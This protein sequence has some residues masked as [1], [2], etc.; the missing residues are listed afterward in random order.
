MNKHFIWGLAGLLGLLS[1]AFAQGTVS[2]D[3]QTQRFI[4]EV[5]TFERD[6]YLTGHFVFNNS[7]A[8]FNAFKAAYDIGGSYE[9]SRQ[10]WSPL[11]KVNNGQI[12]NIQNKYD[13]VRTV[14]PGL[15]G[16]SRASKLMYDASVDYSTADISAWSLQLAAYVAGSYKD[17]WDRMPEFIEPFNEPMVHA[18]D[19]YPGNWNKEKNDLVITKMCEFH[20]DLGQAIHAIPE[21]ENLKMTGYASAFPEFEQNDFDFWNAR[22]K[23][24]IDIA[25]ADV[26]VFSVHLYDGSGLNN[27]GGRRSGSNAE[28]ILDLIEAYSYIALDTVKPLA[29]TEY[30]RLVLSQPG[31]TSGGT[32]SNYEPVEN[33]QA[34]RSQIH[35]AMNFMERGAQMVNTIPF[36]TGKSD[37]FTDKFSRAALFIEQNDGS[38]ALTERKLFYEVWKD[39]KGERVLVRSTNLDVQTQA[40]VDG[41]QLYVVL[42]NL[43]DDPQTVNLNLQDRQG[44]QDVAV[45]KLKIFVDKAPELTSE[46]LSQ[47]PSN[48]TLVFGETVVLTYNFDAPIT[49]DNEIRSEKYYAE[50][51]LAP[52]QANTDA[53]F[54]FEEVVTGDHGLVTL[55]LGVGREHGRS[56]MPS[57]TVNGQ[58]LSVSG[59]LIRGY[60]Q[61]NRSRF[62]GVLEIPVDMDLLIDGSNEVKVQ[63]PDNGGHIASAILQVEKAAQAVTVSLNEV[64]Q[65]Q[66]KLFPGPVRDYLNVEGINP[67]EDYAIYDL[68]GSLVQA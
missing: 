16:T 23:K 14:N 54:L 27:T 28:A 60:D 10:F 8:D 66:V 63:F 33:S 12:P 2:I 21:L 41:N 52:I 61:A 67:G 59:D 32:V 43:N 40:F 65:E 4:G 64:E 37:P 57:I 58:A 51:Y 11:G 1:T 25:G 29:V 18:S 9:G 53:S 68:K 22:Y 17:D 15:V 34:V 35:M 46:T 48:M 56:L 13:G 44:L 3:H 26:D 47:A 36:S 19:F 24:F 45:K 49:F 7:D 39:V 31:W 42:S 5:S 62:F 55:R 30:G 50:S 20:R 38:Y 6:K